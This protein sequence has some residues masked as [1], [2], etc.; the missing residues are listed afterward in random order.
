[1]IEEVV[2]EELAKISTEYKYYTI[3]DHCKLTSCISSYRGRC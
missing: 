1:V 2:E 3:V